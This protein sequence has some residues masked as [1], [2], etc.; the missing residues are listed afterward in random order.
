MLLLGNIFFLL[1]FGKCVSEKLSVPFC[2]RGLWANPQHFQIKHTVEKQTVNIN[3]PQKVV[4]K[5]FQLRLG[6]RC[7]HFS[8]ERICQ[9]L[10]SFATLN[11]LFPKFIATTECSSP[12]IIWL[13]D[14]LLTCQFYSVRLWIFG[15]VK[16]V[17]H[18]IIIIYI[19]I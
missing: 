7:L 18:F 11:V 5:T 3:P 2:W 14:I 9:R 13:A 12:F 15:L 4:L 17:I 1:L 8:A 19:Y 6:G 16:K 10:F